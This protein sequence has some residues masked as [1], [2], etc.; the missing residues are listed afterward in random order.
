MTRSACS[1][2]VRSITQHDD[3]VEV[4]TDALSVTARHVV[5]TVP[6]ALV[7]GIAFDPALP[8]DRA[9]L[10]RK[11]VA[12]P[13]SKTLVVYDEPFW[14]SDGFSGQTAGPKSAAEVT[15]D[16]SPASGS[17]GV[18][19]SFT[20]GSVATRFD[21]LDPAERRRAVLDALTARLGPR[22]RDPGRLHRD[23]VVD[24]GMDARL[25]DGASPARRPHQRTGR[26]CSSRSVGCT[27]PGRRRRRPRTA[28]S[29]AR[30]AP[31]NAPRPRSSTVPSS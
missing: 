4:E 26:S 14:R 15:L 1:S 22:G 23:R 3:R 17:P 10:Y 24:G 13:E 20:F 16:A 30:C 12:G 7:L 28:R 8:D 9:T 5:V 2:P 11:A 25:L 21:A 6:P 27:G 29:T 18:I 31:A 19:A